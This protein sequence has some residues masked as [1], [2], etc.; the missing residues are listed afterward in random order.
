MIEL[1]RNL[2]IHTDIAI[3]NTVSHVSHSDAHLGV[4][5]AI[6]I[7]LKGIG[8]RLQIGFNKIRLDAAMPKATYDYELNC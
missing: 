6:F 8:R 7:S 4:S 1:C 2:N 3:Y 5:A